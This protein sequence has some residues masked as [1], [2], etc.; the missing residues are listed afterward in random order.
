MEKDAKTFY[1]GFADKYD[2]MISDKRYET[3]I[4]FFRNVLNQFKIKTIL[5]CA[6]GT[7]WH[8][9]KLSKL[10]YDVTGSDVS[11]DMINK[12]R[13]NSA[14]SQ[15]KIDICHADFKKLTDAFDKKF[16]CVICWG[17]SLNHESEDG[18]N[19]VLASMFSI[20]NDDGC[21]LVEIRNLPKMK[22]ENTRFIPMHYHKE[23]NG[24]ARFFV[25][26][27]DYHGARATFNVISVIETAGKPKFEVNSSDYCIISADKLKGLMTEAGFSDL[28]IYGDIEFS[29]F[30]HERS[31]GIIIVAKKRGGE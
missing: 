21:L 10:G 8:A 23:P 18:I 2:V 12:A 17:N 19:M 26:V 27:V 31:D 6:C 14:S 29:K 9:I 25:Y 16:D 20:L 15:T 30:N 5:D 3:D 24:D 13:Q 22:N 7:G 4:L 11:E 1:G 28:K